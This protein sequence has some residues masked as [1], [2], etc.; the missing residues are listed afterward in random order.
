MS[1]GMRE[2]PYPPGNYS[3]GWS[4]TSV[5]TFQT[6]KR[7]YYLEKID[8]KWVPLPSDNISDLKLLRSSKSLPILIG[9]SVHRSIAEYLRSRVTGKDMSEEVFV[10]NGSR[11]FDRVLQTNIVEER[12]FMD[13]Q[14]Y[15]SRVKSSKEKVNALLKV[16]WHLPYR[17]DIGS[18]LQSRPDRSF[19]D[20][21]GI[22][23]CYGEFRVGDFKGYGP[24]DLV[25]SP[26]DGRY[27]V[28]SW[29]TG[30]HHVDGFLMQLAGQMLFCI[31]SL[32]LPAEAVSASVINLNDLSAQPVEFEGAS[33]TI[34]QCLERMRREVAEISELF[35]NPSQRVPKSMDAFSVASNQNIC[36][37]CKYRTICGGPD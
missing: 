26:M 33:G 11:M 37:R 8:P 12:R 18:A 24:P 20:P 15:E 7:Q 21:T 25:Y 27:K 34:N 1:P 16:F 13:E 2:K 30:I 17:A 10:V 6:C 28:L 35:D 31:H 5:T 14:S 3:I 32:G 36:T 4:H 23:R 29:K 19:V 22:R 9:D